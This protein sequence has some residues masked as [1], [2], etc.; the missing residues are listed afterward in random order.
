MRLFWRAFVLY[1]VV[2]LFLLLRWPVFDS[3]IHEAAAKGDRKYV[4]T[5]I[6]KGGDVDA[7]DEESNYATPLSCAAANGR[8]EI[9]ELLILNGAKVDATDDFARTPLMRAVENG[10]VDAAAILLKRGADANAK[11]LYSGETLL[12]LAASRDYGEIAIL[13][14]ENGVDVNARNIFDETPLDYAD[15]PKTADILRKYGGR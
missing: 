2:M 10:H 13:L 4:I 7:R 6:S 14:L 1:L 3:P 11:G 9:V 5:Y 12:H 8:T 15:N